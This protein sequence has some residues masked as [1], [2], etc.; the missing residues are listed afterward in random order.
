MKMVKSLLLGSAAGLVAVSAGQ[1][2]DLPVKA[3]PV[4]YVK[5]C[6]LYGA[7]FYY[8][9]GTDMCIKIGG[10]VRAE[11]GYHTNGSI[12][13]GPFNGNA[14]VR[15][16]NEL[17]FRARGYI[18]ADARE[19]TAWGTARGYIAV[20]INMNSV[21]IDTA[22]NQF[23]ANRAFVQ[24][25]GFTAGLT[26]S[27]FD[28]YSV[29]AS[30]YWGIFPA[31]DTGDGGWLVFGYTAQLGNGL[32]ATLSAEGRR[33]TQIVNADPR[34]VGAFFGQ[35]NAT[36]IGTIGTVTP[37]AFANG[38]NTDGIGSNGTFAA[39]FPGIGAY[40]GFN[41]P[42]VVANIRMDQTWGSAQI[43]GAAHK[44]NASAYGVSAVTGGANM[45]TGHP[46]DDWGWVAG[47]GLRLNIPWFAQGDF[48]QTQ[49]NYTQGALKYLF[50]T[51]NSNW[52]KADDSQL[53]FGVLSDAVFGSGTGN[54][55]FFCG[56]NGGGCLGIQKTTGWN[57]NAAFEHYWTPAFH[58]SVYGGY[59][60]VRYN[61]DANTALCDIENGVTNVGGGAVFKTAINRPV[62]GCNN[63]W[64]TWWVGTRTQWDITKSFY[65]GVD[66]LYSKLDSASINSTSTIVAN[67]SVTG[68]QTVNIAGSTVP[69]GIAGSIK[70]VDNWALRFRVHK[71]FLP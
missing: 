30:S 15:T 29:P 14:N 71:D 4:E 62:A 33:M 11:A 8:M 23:S 41:A 32:S 38:A 40:G 17:V 61:D 34:D 68:A 10:Y 18:T 28:F 70:D 47:A 49:A 46:G 12:T 21:G 25:A 31:S 69:N 60:E 45:L 2:A 19:Q 53:A 51:P 50:Q 6:S 37:G 63:N 54:T 16:T 42:D 9:P 26:Q 52:G 7:G 48:F 24:W 27:F 20:G 35:A 39:V 5:V 3:K 65:M 66:V 67:S 43:M 36:V 13:W 58:S 56:S 22:A 55:T 64:N 1:A 59:A 57:V 44:L